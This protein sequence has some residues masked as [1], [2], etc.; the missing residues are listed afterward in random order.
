M[1]KILSFDTYAVEFT[2]LPPYGL[3]RLAMNSPDHR[4]P[5]SS[6]ILSRDLFRGEESLPPLALYADRH[7]DSSLRSE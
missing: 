5:H 4:S 7:R 1:P 2:A 6:V 3:A